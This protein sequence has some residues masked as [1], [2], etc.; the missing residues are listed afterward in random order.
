MRK[1]SLGRKR[2]KSL[3]VGD[4]ALKQI[5]TGAAVPKSVALIEMEKNY[6]LLAEM[7]SSMIDRM[8]KMENEMEKMQKKLAEVMR[9][10]KKSRF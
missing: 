8:H 5:I 3:D 9:A 7:V 2:R 1:P 6:C 10:K 4:K